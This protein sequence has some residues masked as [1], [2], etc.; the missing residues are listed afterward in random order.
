MKSYFISSDIHGYYTIW[1]KA[2]AEAG[3]NVNNEN[4]VL[5][6]LGDLIDRGLENLECLQFVNSLPED[7]KILIRGNHED[8]VEE[9]ICRGYFKQHDIHN[10]THKTVEQVTGVS[11]DNETEALSAMKNNEEWNKYINGCVDYYEL[12]NNI[13]VHGWIPC[14]TLDDIFFYDP[15]WREGDWQSARWYNGMLMWGEGIVEENK[16]IW[17][18]HWH[19]SWG[20]A[21]LH[22]DGVEFL[23]RIETFY[24][25]PDTGKTEPHVNNNTFKDEGIV[26]LDACT[27]IS[28]KVNVEVIEI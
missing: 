25:D 16:T 8:L 12:G 9:A 20:H 5:V 3:F 28:N 4:H 23:Q 2:L 7:R 26:A 11:L 10:C 27:V 18:G 6:V 13:F 24:I 17:C 15:E 22:D 21:N 14:D 1:K 19:T